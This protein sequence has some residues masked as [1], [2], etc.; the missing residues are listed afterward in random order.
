MSTTNARRHEPELMTRANDL[1]TAKDCARLIGDALAKYYV[2][3][4]E[5][6]RARFDALPWWRRWIQ[7]KP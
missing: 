7:G 4:Q 5:D 2:A 3:E 6:R 1:I